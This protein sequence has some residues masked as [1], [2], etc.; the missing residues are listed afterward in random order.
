MFS[1]SRTGHEEGFNFLD[2]EKGAEK[3][4]VNKKMTHCGA[5]AIE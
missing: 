1:N 4:S 2:S 5:R 3:E